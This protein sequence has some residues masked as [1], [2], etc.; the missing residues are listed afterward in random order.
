MITR[1]RLVAL[2][3]VAGS[4]GCQDYLF[5]QKFPEKVKETT[6]ARAAAKPTPADILFVV[7]NSGSM[8]DE[9]ENL[10]RNFD[11]FIQEI[12]G[13]GDYQIG[14]VSTDQINAME[15]EGLAI[16][17]FAPSSPFNLLDFNIG[18][19]TASTIPRGCFR[20]PNA[21]TR[22]IN[23]N[24]IV[25]ANAQ[26][27][28]FQENVRVGSCGAGEET[29]LE[30]MKVALEATGPGECNEGFLRGEA[31]LVVIIVSDEEDA[32]DVPVDQYVQD[33]GAI[34]P[35]AQT[36]V[37]LVVG[38]VD[39]AASNCQIPNNGTCGVEVCTNP[40]AVGSHT[41]C[42][43]GSQCTNGEFC[44]TINDWCENEA[45]RHFNTSFCQW[46]SYFNT[47]DCCSALGGSRYVAF[48]RAMETRIAAADSSIPPQQCRGTMENTPIACLTD[49]I[50]QDDFSATLRRIAKEL[51]ITDVYTLVPPAVY[52]PGVKVIVK[53][54]RFPPEG[55]ELVNGTDFEVSADGVTLRLLGE[56]TPVEGENIE[57]FFVT[58]IE[59]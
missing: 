5:E 9:Q 10:A 15:K 25:D 55:K 38:S 4:L 42:T 29:G 11:A 41:P 35:Y 54:G 16:S 43:M 32:G 56:N 45:R 23:S 14:V 22:L 27:E 3:A 40:P 46:C 57:I 47:E 6:I 8:A 19:C 21:A 26:I 18:S 34:K 59:K 31:N 13:P 2:I 30:A 28:A 20:G 49:S 48:A 12:A 17:T 24:V 52:P 58:E 1:L 51:I 36:R 7:D 37:A 50:C 39:G 53:N 44:E 33:L